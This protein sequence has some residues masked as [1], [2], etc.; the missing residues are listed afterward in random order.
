MSNLIEI[1]GAEMSPYSVKLR[2]FCRYKNIPHKWLNRGDHEEAY[3]RLAKLPIIPLMHFPDGTVMQDSTPIMDRL[4]TSFP[5]VPSQ[6]KDPTLHFLSILLEEYGDEWLNK[7]MF[8]FRWFREIDQMTSA[9]I[10]ARAFSASAK[11][12]AIDNAAGMIQQHMSSRGNFVGSS[13][14][15]APLIEQ[16]FFDLMALLEPHLETRP[17]LLGGKPVAGDFGTSAQVYEMSLDPTLGGYL[18]AQYPNTLAWCLR[19]QDPTD[20]GELEAWQSLELTLKPLLKNIGTYF[21]PWSLANA[22]ALIDGAST[23]SVELSGH[24]YSQQPQKYHA[25]SLA[26]LREKFKPFRGHEPLNKI[27][28]DTKILEAL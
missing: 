28:Q 26:V 24:T 18:R 25:K 27:L 12:D 4:E 9:Y 1:Y 13:D 14:E 21:L 23:F 19:M 17:Y 8:H 3:K 20:R 11:P 10:L 2:A 16:Y 6:P 5:E 7:I 22:A 15:T